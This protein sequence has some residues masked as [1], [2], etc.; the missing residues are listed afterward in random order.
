MLAQT[1]MIKVWNERLAQLDQESVARAAIIQ[2]HEQ[3]GGECAEIS[4]L[5]NGFDSNVA[6]AHQTDQVQT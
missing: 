3:L 4:E 2:E 1:V 5:E 6:G